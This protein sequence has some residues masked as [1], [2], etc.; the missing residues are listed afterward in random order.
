MQIPARYGDGRSARRHAVTLTG[1]GAHLRVAGDQVDTSYPCAAVR[2]TEP[3][4]HA[5]TLVYFDDGAHCEVAASDYP[6]LAALL[7]H[8]PSLVVRWQRHW[9]MALAA[10]A[11]L[12]AVIGAGA[13]WGLPAAAQVV[14]ALLPRAA[15]VR[16][17]AFTRQ[18]LQKQ[19]LTR[20][21]TLSTAQH[22][23]IRQAWHAVE[24]AQPRMP[25]ALQVRAMP[26]YLGPNALALPDG[27]VILNDAMA[28]QILG[29]ADRFGASQSAALA[30]VLAHEIGHIEHRHSMRSIVRASLT[31]A[32]AA[33]LF[34]DFS[35]VAAGAPAVL[36]G[37]R[38]SR[39]METE[40]DL[41]ALTTLQARHLPVA[42]LADLFQAMDKGKKE[43]GWVGSASGY[44]SSHPGSAQRAALLRATR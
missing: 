11:M 30:G 12:V 29:K 24:P 28:R 21:S 8:R 3:F 41:Y 20:P 25:M 16:I 44:L 37:A 18:A 27:T 4:A 5:A 23:D 35:A 43:D 19:G 10:S 31:T 39:D 7:G 26:G 42:P 34:G 36:L 14:T 40:A 2:V 32:F 17:G 6:A 33:F 13:V 38:H 9:R 22:D 15:D 1:A